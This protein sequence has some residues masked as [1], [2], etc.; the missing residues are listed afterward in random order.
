DVYKR[1][2]YVSMTLSKKNLSV[3]YDNPALFDRNMLSS[4]NYAMD[5]TDY[6]QPAEI[7]IQLTHKDVVLNAFLNKRI[8]FAAI[9]SGCVLTVGDDGLYMGTK[10]V[11]KY[12]EAF[13]KK[14]QAL[15]AKGYIPSSAKVRVQ[16]FWHHE[17]KEV[18]PPRWHHD[19]ILLPDIVLTMKTPKA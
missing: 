12:S 15:D 7:L 5:E 19:L 16:V 2:V 8:D 11:V 4:V 13:T 6:G 9:H 14:L 10:R 1:Q 3:H 18:T 17:D